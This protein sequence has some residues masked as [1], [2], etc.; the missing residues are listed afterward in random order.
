MIA[1]QN[2]YTGVILRAETYNALTY[3]EKQN[4]V[5]IQAEQKR[6]SNG[7]L[8]LSAVVGYAT[9]SFLLGGLVGGSLTGGLLG[10]VLNND[11]DSS[12]LDIFD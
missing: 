4:F 6:N 10:D 9:N 3:S 7:D 12:I 11:S 8:I 2:K 5:A 1:Y